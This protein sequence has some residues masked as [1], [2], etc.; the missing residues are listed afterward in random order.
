M[1]TS[2]KL[3]LAFV[4]VSVIPLLFAAA[5]VSQ[6]MKITVANYT[7]ARLQT[8]IG[9]GVKSMSLYIEENI[10]DFQAVGLAMKTV[11]TDPQRQRELLSALH[12]HYPALVT[13]QLMDASGRIVAS[14]GEQTPVLSRQ[15]MTE[16]ATAAPGL[17][18]ASNI[19]KAVSQAKANDHA[20]TQPRFYIAIAGPNHDVQSILVGVLDTT[21]LFEML[22]EYSLL[23]DDNVFIVDDENRV[24][25][26]NGMTMGVG[27]LLTPAH[28]EV[29]EQ[30]PAEAPPRS[31]VLMF[32]GEKYYVGMLRMKHFAANNQG[33]WRFVGLL[34][35]DAVASTTLSGMRN[36]SFALIVLIAGA[37]VAAL[38]LTRSFA[39]PITR[40]TAGARAMAAG[41][42]SI[43]VDPS[44]NFEASQLAAAFNQMAEAV[45]AE[46]Q[47][48]EGEISVRKAQ[49]Q[50]LIHARAAAEAAN[51][52]KSEFLANM[53]HEIR[54]PMNGVLGFTNLLLDTQLDVQQR[55]HVVTI[56][57]SAESLLNIINDILDFSKVEAG[58]MT[59]EHVPYDLTR[60]T[61]EVVELLA[62]QAEQKGIELALN[63]TSR[64]PE[65]MVGDPGRTRQVML[66]LLGNAIK[67]TRQGH[68][69]VE[70]QHVAAAADKPAYL[71]F[72]V[73]DTGVGIPTEKQSLLFR[74]FSQADAS[75]TR[76]FGGTG[77]GLAISKR[78]VELMGGEIGFTS[79]PS[80][81]STFWFTLPVP[82]DARATIEPKALPSLSD[83]RVL[84]VDD[85]E[86]NRRLASEQ[87]TAWGIKHE[88]A[89]SGAQALDMLRS[90]QEK[91]RPFDVAVLDFLM[92]GMDGLELGQRI[93]GDPILSTTALVALTSGSQRSASQT[94]I[95]AGF[96]VFLLKP[97]VRPV[98]LL[99]AIT[100]ACYSRTLA[101]SLD[102]SAPAAP[103]AHT[104]VAQQPEPVTESGL[105][106]R[107][108]VAED[109]TVNQRLVKHMLEKM[110]CRVD[111][112]ANG[113]EAITMAERLRY[114]LI[115][116][117]C[118]MPELDGYAAT[119][120]LRRRQ[121]ADRV[122]IVALTANAMPEDREKCLAAGMDDYLSKP[123]YRDNLLQMIER[124]VLKPAA[125]AAAAAS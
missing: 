107:V 64:V 49:E 26:G 115:L 113:L 108:L 63:V 118:L 94:F 105:V 45:S 3:L 5:L 48:L 43:R 33:G 122:P 124:W 112:A 13:L 53:S 39:R 47:A 109:N 123:I 69:L 72:A 88:C 103:R 83:V 28:L 41:D 30:L 65:H 91:G 82:A 36:G 40:L 7:A 60:A 38:W 93:K 16:L 55:D 102:A 51:R 78:L 92:P 73:T 114:D 120:E 20:S 121:G 76:E 4:L 87:L 68:V 81:G 104:P 90:A 119:A 77:L 21:Y 57:N 117:D 44:N 110:G 106:V 22:K 67:F 14:T 18:Y 100:Q 17:V 32:N 50:E 75:T 89:E 116:M 70:L 66:N 79:E 24:V 11:G 27:A 31:P 86:L 10:R 23:G 19:S 1:R 35:H 52:A 98:Q 111:V 101:T 42:Y 2:R 25:F 34:D 71:R 8:D 9:L 12:Q 97:V 74:H 59:V 58:K 96:S 15:D 125:Q 54:T 29:L 6:G 37:I 46:K 95:A 84:V 99:D 56:R 62:P 85:Y 80:R 61:A